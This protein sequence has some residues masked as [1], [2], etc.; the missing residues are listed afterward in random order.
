[1]FVCKLFV[2]LVVLYCHCTVAHR[3]GGGHR[4][5]SWAASGHLRHHREHVREFGCGFQYYRTFYLDAKRDVLYV[6]AMD[7]LYRLNLNNVN[8]SRCDVDALFLDPQNV[9]NCVSKGKSE[10]YD[11]R[12]HIRVIQPIG[13]GS[14]LYLCGT[15][16]HNPRDL[17]IYGNLSYLTPNEHF[18]GIGDGIAKCPF[19]PDDNATAVWVEHGNPGGLPGLYS[20]TVAEFTK[21]D[22]VIF[23]TNLYNLTSGASVHPFKRT[24]KY[25]SKWLDKPHF[26]GSYDIGDYVYFFFR[27]S[28]VEYINCGKNI[29]SRV[30]RV[31]KRDTGGKN[32]LNKNWASFLKA[33]LNCSIPGEFPFYFNEIQH[34]Y[35]HPDDEKK[36]YAVFSTSTN[37]LMG[38][39]IC[40]YSLDSIQEV[41]NGKF[42]EQATSSSA[43][44]PVLTSK[45][46]EPRPGLCVND[47]QTL[48]DSVLNFI[49][50]HPLM[51][52][53]VSHDNAKPV[54]YKRDVIFTSLV[55]DMIEVEGVQYTVYYAG[56]TEGYIYKLVEWYDRL[57]EEHSNLVDIF[58][59]T[60]PET[61]RAI[62][63][64][65]KHKSLYVSSDYVLRQFDLVMCKGR[66]ANCLRCIQD[67]YCGWDKERGECKPYVN[68]LLQDVTN[69]TPGTCD[70]CVKNKPMHV[71]WGQSV[72]LS[73]AIHMPDIES[74]GL[75]PLR[76][77]HYSRE[78]GKYAVVHRRE[79]YIHTADHGIVILSVSE[80]DAGRY[81]CKL[82]TSTL[83]SFNITV[84]T[85]T[86]SAPSEAEYRKIYSDWCHEFEK[87]KMAMKTWQT[88]QTKC[89]S[90]HPNDVTY[91]GGT[92]V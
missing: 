54:Y 47:T 33:R 59:A 13:D 23:R 61:V 58:E 50:G 55:V 57:G 38:S 35:K 26:V 21:A 60:V 64:S 69:A 92:L 67:P 31:C 9:A 12:N 73:C 10:R 78:K 20:G 18:P 66:Y 27:E 89:Q 52:S 44:L 6:G 3:I 62:E 51:D 71:F 76:W 37:G 77:Y 68:G 36:F 19:D 90:V 17:V 39:A 41:F 42:K 4:W 79:K 74:M 28:A 22:T 11:C 32:I 15:N 72:H 80:R 86:C 88:K 40:S 2:V 82:G 34:V 85:K 53:A 75:G 91:Q 56:S 14:K 25:D 63:I 65:S 30:A 1:M 87:Y 81:D 8:K 70:N 46:P 5:Y 43:W 48:P 16:A 49:R 7:R 84:D 24:I 83:C 29:Y 45:V